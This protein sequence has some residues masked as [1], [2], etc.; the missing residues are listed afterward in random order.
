MNEFLLSTINEIKR[1]IS[2]F[3]DLLSEY[4]LSNGLD[5]LSQAEEGFFVFISKQ[6]LF[7]KDLNNCY[8]DFKLKVLISDYYNYIVSIIRNENRYLYL[9]E[10]S[11][12]EGYTRFIVNVNVEQDHVTSGL[13]AQLKNNIYINALS[14]DEYGLIKSEYSTSC[15]FIHGS[16][17]LNGNLS[18]YFNEC[19]SNFPALKNINS[20]YQK[21]IKIIKIFNRMIISNRTEQIDTI[22]W[23]KKSILEYLIG[24]ENVDI[25]FSLRK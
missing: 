20:Y 3:V 22:F 6:I 8:P 9:N 12:I 4:A 2:Q 15:G 16:R 25:L 14:N 24:K 13:I 21:I 5:A 17:L 18:Y 11:I 7:L 1:S 10:R 19:V 23:S